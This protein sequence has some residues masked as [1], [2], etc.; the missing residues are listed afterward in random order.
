MINC[1]VSMESLQWD[2]FCILTSLFISSHG[3]V[4]IANCQSHLCFRTSQLVFSQKLL[5]Y[6]HLTWAQGMFCM[7]SW[8]LS[9]FM[10]SLIFLAA[11]PNCT[12]PSCQT[13]AWSSPST[14]KA[15]R[16]SCVQYTASSTDLPLSWSQRLCLSMTSVI[17]VC[18]HF[19]PN[20]IPAYENIQLCKYDTYPPKAFVFQP[21]NLYNPLVLCLN[22]CCLTVLHQHW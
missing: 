21:C 19:L 11:R 10:S 15:G 5:L 12:R 17:K 4:Q 7:W 1:F 8:H 13:P 22:D 2:L 9:L 6:P 3:A 16:L 18:V 14:M 20:I